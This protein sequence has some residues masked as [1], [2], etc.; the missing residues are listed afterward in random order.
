[1]I[2]V[3]ETPNPHSLKFLPH[4]L[5]IPN[6]LTPSRTFFVKKELCVG[7]PFAK[8]ILKV[9]NIQAVFLGK[10]FITI[11]KTVTGDW[12]NLRPQIISLIE[13]YEVKGFFER[14]EQPPVIDNCPSPINLRENDNGVSA[15]IQELI[16]TRVRPAVLQD[17]GDIVFE[18]FDNGIVYLRMQGACVGCPSSTV[19]LKL[20]IER[21]LKHFVPE[22]R[23]VEQIV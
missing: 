5:V 4:N 8:E 16:H 15:Q 2:K 21:M 13:K 23:S 9:Q 3:Q 6:D 14:T 17:G 11:T 22:V 18:R 10:E 1:M 7:S 19:T 20:G 12:F